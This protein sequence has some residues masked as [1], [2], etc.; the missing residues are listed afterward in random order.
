MD[1]K[2]Q[3]DAFQA[4]LE[5]LIDRYIAEFNLSKASAIGVLQMKVIWLSPHPGPDEDE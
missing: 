4:D 2:E 3:Q 1:E 5:R